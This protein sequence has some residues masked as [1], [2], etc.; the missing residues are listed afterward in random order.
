M[1]WIYL[2]ERLRLPLPSAITCPDT[3]PSDMSRAVR[4]VSPILSGGSPTDGLT[5]LPF[6]MTSE[7]LT[8]DCIREWL[9]SLPPVSPVSLIL[10]QENAPGSMTS[11][12][13]GRT[14]SESLA[15]YDP[16]LCCWRTSQACFPTL[17]SDEFSATWPASG[18]VVDGLLWALP[19]WEQT[20]GENGFGF[21]P[22]PKAS[23]SG[24]D[25]ARA[26]RPSSAGDD[27]A[28][29]VAREIFPTPKC[30]DWKGQTQR[31]Q[32]RPEDGLCNF[33]GVTGGQLNPTWIEWL[34]GWPIGW[35]ESKPLE[36]ASFRTWLEGYSAIIPA[37]PPEREA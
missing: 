34:M 12:I 32:F 7:P 29:A 4:S 33:L 15:R 3:V 26:E 36:T 10:L 9:T 25:F 8:A 24:P 11:E 23:A 19:T 22:T 35:T 13:C 5:T 16:V 21:W 30:R 20:T 2:P 17:M 18:I 6:G 27:L 14:P 37:L 28:T 31:G 1:A